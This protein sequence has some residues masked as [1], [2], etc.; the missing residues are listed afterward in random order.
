MDKLQFIDEQNEARKV[1]RSVIFW[2]I[3]YAVLFP[4]VFCF[5][6]LSTMIFDSPHITAANGLPLIFIFFLLPF[7]LPLSIDLMWSSYLCKEY[8]K[9]T[10]FCMFPL[11]T[12]LCICV[13]VS[14]IE[15]IFVHALHL[16]RTGFANRLAVLQAYHQ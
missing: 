12:F 8:R 13:L 9:I 1:R 2:T 4:L 5:S 6:L 7:S 15:T 10:F 11:L 14:L 16:N 3:L